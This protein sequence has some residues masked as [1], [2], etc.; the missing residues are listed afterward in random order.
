MTGR[1]IVRV[2]ELVVRAEPAELVALG[3]GSCV[4]VALY[5]AVA[6][7]AG[8]AHVLLPAPVPG[9]PPGP[10]GRHAQTA[11]PALVERMIEAGAARMRLTARL[12]GGS[13]MFAALL[14][15]GTIHMGARNTV[16]THEALHQLRIRIAGEWVGGDFGRS[17]YFDAASGEVRVTSVGHGTRQL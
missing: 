7:V 16:A 17:V 8:M 6:R 15:P 14:A 10:I 2:A 13:S 9:R 5:D 4:A 3:L 12:A 1:I 11:I